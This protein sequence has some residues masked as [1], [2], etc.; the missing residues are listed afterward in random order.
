MLIAL[1]IERK[2][3][4]DGSSKEG[5]KKNEN[6][7]QVWKKRNAPVKDVLENT[8]TGVY[9]ASAMRCARIDDDN[10]LFAIWQDAFVDEGEKLFELYGHKGRVASIIS[11]IE[12]SKDFSVPP[13]RIA[14]I[15]YLYLLEEKVD[16]TNQEPQVEKKTE[17]ETQD[18]EKES[19]KKTLKK[20]TIHYEDESCVEF[21]GLSTPFNHIVGYLFN[22]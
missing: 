20:V 14:R 19:E 12:R 17:L 21:N 13:S 3:M 5:M 1:L 9:S 16:T 18:A 7:P 11:S 8:I 4:T 6:Y 2:K 15:D 10:F 22:E